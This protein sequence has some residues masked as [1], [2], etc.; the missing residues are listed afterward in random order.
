VPI[1]P[2][3]LFTAIGAR[4][5][6]SSP[7]GVRIPH[8]KPGVYFVSLTPDAKTNTGLLSRA[9]ISPALVSEWIGRVPTFAFDGKPCRADDVGSFLA[10]A[11]LP[12]ESIVY[13]GRATKS[14]AVRTGQFFRHRLGERQPHNGGHWVKVLS[15]LNDL[16][17][18]YAGCDNETQAKALE[19][20]ALAEFVQQVSRTTRERLMNPR[21]PIP[22]A[23]REYPQGTRKQARIGRDVLR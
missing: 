22:F 20:R 5:S 6:G 23:N 12:D 7:W 14:L 19:E 18:H 3:Q 4:R 9:P 11:W 17:L 10:T 16:F 8:D 1:S 21:I 15:N 2:E 13:I